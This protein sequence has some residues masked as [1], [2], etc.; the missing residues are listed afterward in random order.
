MNKICWYCEKINEG[1]SADYIGDFNCA[2]CGVMNSVLDNVHPNFQPGN[3][4]KTTETEWLNE[5]EPEGEEEMFDYNNPKYQGRYVYLPKIG[6]EAEFDI[7][8]I[9]EVKSDN[10]KFNFTENIPVIVDGEQLIDDDGE[11]VFKKK[12]LGYHIEVDLQDG[13]ILSITSLGT[14]LTVFKKHNIQHEEKVRISHPERGVWKI[15][16]L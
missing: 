1:I 8:E 4:S 16:K 2:F 12:D 14:F 7:K 11:L 6:E 9:R 3:E 5:T 13:K 15:T 10:E